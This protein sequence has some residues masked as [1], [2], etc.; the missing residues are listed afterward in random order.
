MDRRRSGNSPKYVRSN[1]IAHQQISSAE[2]NSKTAVNARKKSD[3]EKG[4]GSGRHGL[5]GAFGNT[6]S[7]DEAGARKSELSRATGSWVPNNDIKGKSTN[8]KHRIFIALFSYDPAT[9][10]P[11]PDGVEEELP[12]KEGQLIRVRK[13][14]Q[15]RMSV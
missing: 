10:S 5:I 9:M 11:N 7:Q 14:F 12:F 15:F 13:N 8:N 2:M 4:H 1:T 3:Q 6:Y